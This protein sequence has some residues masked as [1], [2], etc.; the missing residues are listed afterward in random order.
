MALLAGDVVRLF[1]N[2]TD[3]PKS[4]RFVCVDWKE[5]W[6]LRIDSKL[7]WPPH[8]SLPLKGNE[9]CL[10]HDSFV[11][12]NTV[13]EF[14]DSVVDESLKVPANFLG[15]IADCDRQRLYDAVQSAVTLTPEQRNTICA[16]LLAAGSSETDSSQSQQP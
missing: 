7:L 6:F 9:G 13:L 15:P 14:D 12:L 11:E 16:N 2:L 5:G 1:D 8:L 10:D 4:K 3:P